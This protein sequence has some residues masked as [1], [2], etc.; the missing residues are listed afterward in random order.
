MYVFT[1]AGWQGPC[2]E[3][4]DSAAGL[5]GYVAGF[6]RGGTK[7]GESV[8]VMMNKCGSEVRA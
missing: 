5:L 3:R 1:Y 2:V 7:N 8:I 4:F 6:T